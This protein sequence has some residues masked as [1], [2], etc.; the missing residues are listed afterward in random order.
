MTNLQE[1]INFAVWM[2]KEKNTTLK[3]EVERASFRQKY[4][5]KVHIEKVVKE[6][7]GSAFF[8]QRQRDNQPVKYQQNRNIKMD[9]EQANSIAA[10][11]AKD[12]FLKDF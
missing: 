2:I 1:A 5:V 4:G 3:H 12:D 11:K 9:R 6:V 7:L 8:K 10:K